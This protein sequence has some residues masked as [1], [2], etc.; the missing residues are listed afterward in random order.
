M[1][2]KRQRGEQSPVDR[3][4]AL[5]SSAGEPVEEVLREVADFRLALETDMII[6]AAAV[7]AG[8]LELAGDVVD[9]DRAGLAAFHERMLSR[10]VD[11]ARAD[12]AAEPARSR[13]P[14][15][16]RARLVG[17]AAALIALVGGGV[18]VT[19]STPGVES[20]TTEQ[21]ALAL[22]DDQLS[23]L[24]GEIVREASTAEISTAA[25]ELHQTLETLIAEHAEGD[26]AVAAM[27]ARLINEEER[28]L[29]VDS[30][31][32]TKSMLRDVARLVRQLKRVAP[33]RVVATLPAVPASAESSPSAK[34]SSSP[35]PKPSA[36]P[37]RS[38][39]PS[40]SRSASAS[41]RPSTSPSSNS[42]DGGG[43][44]PL[45]T[46]GP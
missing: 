17:A 23:T 18:T 38:A 14:R 26:P 34:P 36:S 8:E 30:N 41:P 45:P 22:A 33:P 2:R 19:S 42:G 31:P 15:M 28:L 10:L 29:R 21:V 11:V 25:S 39:Q 32:V 16:S 5:A 43:S 12:G 35:K 37:S 9:G 20:P 44:Q 46:S 27:I 24:T 4:A 7:D 6:A 1:R 40:P 3:I 13:A